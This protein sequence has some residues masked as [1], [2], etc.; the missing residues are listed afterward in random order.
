M[1]VGANRVSSIR[2][3]RL[4]KVNLKLTKVNDGSF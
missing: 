2:I 3:M 4:A 1:V